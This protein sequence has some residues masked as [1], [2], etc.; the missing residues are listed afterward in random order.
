MIEDVRV[1]KDMFTEGFTGSE[2]SEEE[3]SEVY[4]GTASAVL[5]S[6]GP[7]GTFE[8]FCRPGDS[9][10]ALIRM[11]PGLAGSDARAELLGIIHS[12]LWERDRQTFL[13]FYTPINEIKDDLL[14]ECGLELG[15]DVESS[16]S[17]GWDYEEL[18]RGRSTYNLT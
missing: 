2:E 4:T 18:G 7:D 12:I 8:E 1:S 5:G 14:V 17:T 11:V 3:L 16:S 9:G 13:S 15:M 6:L 10:S